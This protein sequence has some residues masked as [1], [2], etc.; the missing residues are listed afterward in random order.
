[1]QSI[2]S[3][4]NRNGFNKAKVEALAAELEL[5][6]INAGPTKMLLKEDAQTLRKAYFERYMSEK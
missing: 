3:F 1:M 5:N 4:T 6:L 2:S